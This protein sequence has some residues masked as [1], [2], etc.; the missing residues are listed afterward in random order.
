[1]K[2]NKIMAI[3]LYRESSGVGLKEAKDYIDSLS[4]KL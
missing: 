1:M 4:K 2:G 3:K